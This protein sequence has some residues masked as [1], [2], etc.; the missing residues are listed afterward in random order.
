MK[1]KL[2]TSDVDSFKRFLSS[3][4]SADVNSIIFNVSTIVAANLRFFSSS[5]ISDMVL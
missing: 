2:I 1:I 5:N 3:N 4:N